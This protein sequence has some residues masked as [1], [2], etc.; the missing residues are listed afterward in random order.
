MNREQTEGKLF[1]VQRRMSSR[2]TEKREEGKAD[3]P[4]ADDTCLVSSR[5]LNAKRSSGKMTDWIRNITII[6]ATFGLSLCTRR[7]YM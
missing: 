6:V 3:E 2:Q 1:G 7:K 5:G 4:L